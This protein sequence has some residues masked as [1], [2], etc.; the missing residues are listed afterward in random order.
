LFAPL[1]TEN[2]THRKISG[3]HRKE[4]ALGIWPNILPYNQ[5]IKIPRSIVEFKSFVL[6]LLADENTTGK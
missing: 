5:Q 2:Y 3:G 6:R 1:I 4:A